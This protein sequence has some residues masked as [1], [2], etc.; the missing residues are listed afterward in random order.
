MNKLV[1]TGMKYKSFIVL[2]CLI[3]GFGNPITKF[4]YVSM[5]PFCYMAVRFTLATLV[6]AFFFRKQIKKDLQWEKIKGC[7][8]IGVFMA[9]TYITANLAIAMAMVTIA[10]F[11]LGIPVIF[12]ML[13]S[14]IFLKERI[15][16]ASLLAIV[17]VVVG[18]YMLCSGGTGTLSFGAGEIM[19]LSCSL[20]MALTLM[21]SEKYIS[22]VEPATVSVAQCGVSAIASI[23]FAFIFEDY[24]CLLTPDIRAW[25]CVIYLVLGCTVAAFIL[26]NV[27]I[28]HVSAMF[29]S[30]AM[31][32]EPLFTAIFSYF[33]LGEKIGIIGI[34]GSAMMLAGVVIASIIMEKR[35]EKAEEEIAGVS[36]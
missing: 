5:T 19:A 18:T 22:E 8:I 35:Q 9:A 26:Q 23:V 33:F 32:M 28:S 17:L 30:L 24:S 6:F 13:I 1:E 7:L 20:F 14:V 3:W 2:E 16:K 36:S 4:V 12:T 25:V 29:A 27:A 21:A 31:C 11:L 15:R 10:G 34:L